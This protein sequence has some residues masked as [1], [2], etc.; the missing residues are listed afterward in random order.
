MLKVNFEKHQFRFIR[1]RAL[2]AVQGF[3]SAVSLHELCTISFFLIHVM[4]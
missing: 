4:C 2:G 3:I 1:C